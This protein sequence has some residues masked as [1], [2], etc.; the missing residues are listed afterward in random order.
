MWSSVQV[1]SSLINRHV[2]CHDLLWRGAI[3][4]G[5]GKAPVIIGGENLILI[6]GDAYE[7]R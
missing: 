5:K 4:H 2:G 1:W 7:L 6:S 3:H